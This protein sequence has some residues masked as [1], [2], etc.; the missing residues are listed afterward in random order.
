MAFGSFMKIFLPKDRV[1]YGLFEEV[2]SNLTHMT[3]LFSSAV[4]EQDITKRN[5]L[6][7]GLE[8]WEHKNDEVTHKIFIELGRNFITPFDREDIHYL[9]TSL[10][11]VADFIWG[12]GKR[13][14]NY[15]IDDID[16]TT[17]EFASI[18]N[19]SI[20][21]L[22][23]A[24]YGLRDMKDL[25]SLTE[26][27]VLINSLENE[28]DDALDKGMMQ[29]FTSNT[30]AVEIIKKKDLYQMLEIVTDKCEDA[31]NVIESIIIKYV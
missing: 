19:R 3:D 8:E 21:A 25:R 20:K 16:E 24:V 13:M 18:I 30:N 29:L 26:A 1:F 28:G 5:T 4:K 7:K 12:A 2:S 14:M 6:L 27:C 9:A 15:Y 22:N 11:D 10:D 17:H 31:A 23:K